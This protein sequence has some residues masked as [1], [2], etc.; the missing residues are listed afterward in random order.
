MGELLT[1]AL[2][3]A[4]ILGSGWLVLDL[5]NSRGFMIAAIAGAWFVVSHH[6]MYATTEED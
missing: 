5:T 2:H 3:W 6:K 1:I 4:F